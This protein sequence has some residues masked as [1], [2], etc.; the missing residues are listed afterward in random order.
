VRHSVARDELISIWS[1]AHPAD[2]TRASTAPSPSLSAGAVVRTGREAIQASFAPRSPTGAQ[3]EGSL[4][5]YSGPA[6]RQLAEAAPGY[7][8]RDTIYYAPADAAETALRARLGLTDPAAM[9]PAEL[10]NPI[11]DEA[12]RLAVRD[13][14][15]SGAGVTSH[16]DIFNILN[17]QPGESI[18]PGSTAL[19]AGSIQARVELPWLRRLGIGMGALPIASGALTIA[20]SVQQS[21][22]TGSAAPV[23]LGVVSGSL[24]ATGGLA[25]IVGAIGSDGAMMTAGATVSEVGGVLA[26]PLLIWQNIE[27]AVENQRAIQPIAD[28]MRE[29]GNEIGAA[30]ISMPPMYAY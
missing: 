6:A 10:Y 27:M 13:A 11:W 23:A 2:S 20:G 21:E 5:L 25:Y 29:E 16:N 1:S 26:L 7:M 12:S 8:I 18:P 17:L 3:L 4:N 22:E 24:E 28:R 30:L 15:L 14:T 9:L 19:S